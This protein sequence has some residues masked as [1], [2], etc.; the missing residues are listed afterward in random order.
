MDEAKKAELMA[1]CIECDSKK[2][3][4]M[5]HK[6]GEPCFCGSGKP[7]GEC[8]MASPEAHGVSP[9]EMP[10]APEMPSSM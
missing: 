8:C 2:P 3:A 6:S 9:E 1:L 5:C 4:G 10:K 7:V